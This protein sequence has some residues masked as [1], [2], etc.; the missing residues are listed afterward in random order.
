MSIDPSFTLRSMGGELIIKG[1]IQN[2][3]KAAPASETLVVGKTRLPG[4][5][6]PENSAGN[7]KNII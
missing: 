7:D 1:L 4:K 3:E 2:F 5:Q 6:L